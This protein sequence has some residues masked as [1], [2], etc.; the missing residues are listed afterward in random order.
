MISK[1]VPEVGKNEPRVGPLH[2]QDKVGEKRELE[3]AD[4]GEGEDGHVERHVD[5]ITVLRDGEDLAP[6]V[7]VQRKDVAVLFVGAVR[8]VVDEVTALVDV[9]A[10]A[11]GA[12]EVVAAAVVEDAVGQGH[13][14]NNQ[15]RLLADALV[16]QPGGSA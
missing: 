5:R 4:E 16:D 13:V 14:V 15:A 8:A 1:D 12:G 11:V 10:G 2:Q 9:D 7:R 3:C 6:V